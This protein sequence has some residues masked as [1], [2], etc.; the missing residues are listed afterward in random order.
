MC[1]RCLQHRGLATTDMA[2]GGRGIVLSLQSGSDGL[3]VVCDCFVRFAYFFSYVKGRKSVLY[4]LVEKSGWALV[5]TSIGGFVP[6]WGFIPL[7]VVQSSGLSELLV[8]LEEPD[9]WPSGDAMASGHLLPGR[10]VVLRH[11]DIIDMLLMVAL[12]N[13]DV[14]S[15]ERGSASGSGW[16]RS[17]V[18]RTTGRFLQGQSCNFFYLRASL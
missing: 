15:S 4:Q 2:A 11:V 12:E 17:P 10:S 8:I 16:L 9:L 3:V 14:S 18:T 1:P 6:L 13:C 7:W 5:P